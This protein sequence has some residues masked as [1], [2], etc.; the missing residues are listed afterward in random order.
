[1]AESTR[2]GIF[3]EFVSPTTRGPQPFWVEV[4]FGEICILGVVPRTLQITQRFRLLIG[5]PDRRHPP[6]ADRPQK[7]RQP[8]S[9][10]PIRLHPRPLL[11]TS[12]GATTVQSIPA[13]FNRRHNPNPV[14]P[15]S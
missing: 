6:K 1:M 7:V 10:P 15:A 5:N 14:G 11:G 12:D 13:F 9:I 2:W 8:P 3:L 4:V